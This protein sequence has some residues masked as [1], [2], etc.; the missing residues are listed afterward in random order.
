MLMRKNICQI[1]K[2]TKQKNSFRTFWREVNTRR[3][4]L[5]PS[6]LENTAAAIKKNKNKI[7]SYCLK[8]KMKQTVGNIRNNT[9]DLPRS[10]NRND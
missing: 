9:L 2:K 7:S 6:A 4:T 8:P 5:P 1:E 10:G 3:P